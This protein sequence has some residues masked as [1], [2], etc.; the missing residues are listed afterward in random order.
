MSWRCHQLST[1]FISS[2]V[3]IHHCMRIRFHKLFCG[4]LFPTEVGEHSFG[5]LRSSLNLRFLTLIEHTSGVRVEIVLAQPQ[6]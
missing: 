1:N 3:M 6:N 4:Q 2:V 5:I